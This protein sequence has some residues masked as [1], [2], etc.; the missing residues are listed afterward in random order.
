MS[1][2]TT[3]SPEL[4]EQ[5]QENASVVWPGT[6][7]MFEVR[8]VQSSSVNGEVFVSAVLV[9]LGAAKGAPRT[10]SGFYTTEE[11]AIGDVDRQLKYMVEEQRELQGHPV[12]G[13]THHL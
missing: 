7:R 3:A 2:S 1:D 9:E 13:G 6:D 11:E 4:L 12:N 8:V 10:M 5:I